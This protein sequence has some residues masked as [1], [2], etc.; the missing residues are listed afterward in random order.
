MPFRTGDQLDRAKSALQK[1][2][3]HYGRPSAAAKAISVFPTHITTWKNRG[4][5][6]KS[7]AVKYAAIPELQLTKEDFRPDLDWTAYGVDN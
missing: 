6:S 1:V 3:T 4:F 2:L 5:V 7:A